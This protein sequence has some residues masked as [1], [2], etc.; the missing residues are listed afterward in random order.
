MLA[1]TIGSC[2]SKCS[3]MALVLILRPLMKLKNPQV[4]PKCGSGFCCWAANLLWSRRREKALGWSPPFLC[5]SQKSRRRLSDRNSIAKFR[6]D[7]LELA[8]A[9]LEGFEE[10]GIELSL[11]LR[12]QRHHGRMG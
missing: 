7:P 11:R 10:R 6:V 5:N 8:A 9:V 3:I 2:P 4:Y 1:P 12:D